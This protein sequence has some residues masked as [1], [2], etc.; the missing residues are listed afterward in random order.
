MLEG[1]TPRMVGA[2]CCGC[3]RGVGDSLE[4]LRSEILVKSIFSG[5]LGAK[6]PLQ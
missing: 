3:C 4:V 5:V 6:W 1:G 2:K